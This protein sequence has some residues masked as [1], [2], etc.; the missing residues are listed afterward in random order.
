MG[1]Q[2]HGT[3]LQ[4]TQSQGIQPQGTQSQETQPQAN[5]PQ[6]T[7]PQLTRTTQGRREVRFNRNDNTLVQG[8]QGQFNYTQDTRKTQADTVALRTVSAILKYGKKKALVN[9]FLD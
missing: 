7:Q 3:Q 8:T 5:Q 4:G 6:T 2:P 9:C 1:C